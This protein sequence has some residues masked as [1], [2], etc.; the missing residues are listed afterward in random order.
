MQNFTVNPELII[1]LRAKGV[2]VKAIS[3]RFCL[4]KSTVEDILEEHTPDEAVIAFVNDLTQLCGD[5]PPG[6]CRQELMRMI[7][8][9][10][11]YQSLSP[12]AKERRIIRII[13][14]GVF[15]L[16]DIIRESGLMNGEA[17]EILDRLTCEGKILARPRGGVLNRGRKVKFHYYPVE[18]NAFPMPVESSEKRAT[19]DL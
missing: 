12:L 4:P 17:S 13:E 19:L 10:R 15:N 8:Y 16:E 18:N 6:Y 3:D 7:E 14:S 2:S 1:R 5:V 11:K 9:L